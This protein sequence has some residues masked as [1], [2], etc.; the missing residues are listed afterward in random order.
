MLVGQLRLLLSSQL[1]GKPSHVHDMDLKD[2]ILRRLRFQCGYAN[3]F[4]SDRWPA[5]LRL[6]QW[7]MTWRVEP[8]S[9]NWI[10]SMYWWV[11]PGK[12]AGSLWCCPG[13]LLSSTVRW[14]QTCLS[15]HNCN[16]L[17]FLLL[18]LTIVAMVAINCY[19]CLARIV[20]ATVLATIG[21]TTSG[22]A[23]PTSQLVS[24]GICLL[25]VN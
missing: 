8:V 23:F 7:P 21:N 17:L 1:V 18:L 4:Y 3:I 12:T 20:L 14:P 10:L 9:G 24:F 15:Y 5:G 11:I 22:V 13:E 19:Y 6:D 16:K 2:A 25:Y